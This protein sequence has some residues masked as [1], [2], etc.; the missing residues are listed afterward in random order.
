MQQL[1]Q[2]LIEQYNLSK[3]EATGIVDT[4]KKY[5]A[6]NNAAEETSAKTTEKTVTAQQP[7]AEEGILEKA[8]H[9]VE[10]HIP[11]GLKEKAEEMLGSVGNK[12]K[13][14]FN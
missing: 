12:I 11:G 13:G 6:T 14:M 4:V 1:I 8:T 10:D 2:Q 3:E 5:L 9:F 7:P